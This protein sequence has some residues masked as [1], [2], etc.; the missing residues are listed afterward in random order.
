MHKVEESLRLACDLQSRVVVVH[1]PYF[2]QLEYAKWLKQEIN[3]L[4]RRV[5]VSVAVENAILVN[6]IRR[7]NLSFFNDLEGLSSFDRLVFDTSHFAISN[8]DILLAWEYLKER[9]RHIHLSNNLLQG[10]DDHALPHRGKLPLD[11]FLHLVG[12][13]GYDGLI[14]LELNPRSL[15]AKM[16]RERVIANLRES[17]EFCRANFPR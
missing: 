17:L 11:R 6:F 9:V 10:F 14:V 8:V 12:E 7:W 13:D 16:G 15:E 2:W 1:L 5:E 4:N 3:S